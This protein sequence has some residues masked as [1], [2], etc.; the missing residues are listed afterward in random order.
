MPWI[1]QRRRKGDR[2]RCAKCGKP[3]WAG[4]TLRAITYYYPDRHCRCFQG[5]RKAVRITIWRD[6]A[7]LPK[8]LV[9]LAVAA[10]C[11]ALGPVAAQVAPQAPPVVNWSVEARPVPTL[12]TVLVPTTATEAT[13]APRASASFKKTL[14]EAAAQAFK[15]GEITRWQLARIRMAIRFRPEAVAEIQAAVVDDAVAAGRM[16]PGDAISAAFDWTK[17]LDF[18]KQ[19]LPIILQ[20]I[21][22]FG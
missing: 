7:V 18:I 12:A 17:L 9:C 22:I 21:S 19:L 20:L 15:S 4:S 10:C 16:A 6:P 11:L 13:A 8:I 5:N 14:D 1:F 3:Y 2:P